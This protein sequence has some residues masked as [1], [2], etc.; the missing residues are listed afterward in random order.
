[1][2]K[3]STKALFYVAVTTMVALATFMVVQR[4]M[5]RKK[6]SR[7]SNEGYETA[8]DVLYP[9]N[10]YSAKLKYGPVLPE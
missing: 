7:I 9:D 3:K 6:L 1:M 4:S 2:M 8:I 5:N 10:A